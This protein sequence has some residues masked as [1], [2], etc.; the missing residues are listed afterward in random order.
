MRS[1][2]L[3]GLVLVTIAAC[4]RIAFQPLDRGNDGGSDG[5]SDGAPVDTLTCSPFEAPQPLAINAVQNDGYPWVSTDGLELYFAS[6]RPGGLGGSDLWV[7]TR[8]DPASAFGVPTVVATVSSTTNDRAPSLSADGLTLY[9]TSES[10]PGGPG[11]VDIWRATRPTRASEFDPPA[12]VTELDTPSA[13]RTPAISASGLTI[14]FGSDRPGGAGGY[15]LWVASRSSLASPFETPVRVTELSS[16][17][18]DWCPWLSA[19]ERTLLFAS[20]R[21]GGAGLTDIWIATRDDPAAAF[22]VPE[23]VVEINSAGD[24]ISPSLAPDGRTIYFRST[25]SGGA[26][27]DD[28]WF[29]SRSCQ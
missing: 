6:Y 23:P 24:E 16:T 1:A 26:G 21:P 15:D 11:S 20:G 8:S 7:A 17:S 13:D 28:L 5:A 27:G 4:G 19:D 3:G 2:C 25:R 18:S 22:G 9:F 12:A 10:R 29:A 14:Y